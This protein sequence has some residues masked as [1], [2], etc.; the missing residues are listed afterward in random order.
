MHPVTTIN[1]PSYSIAPVLNII[2]HSPPPQ[3]SQEFCIVR[4]PTISPRKEPYDPISFLF[5]PLLLLILLI[6]PLALSISLLMLTPA[7]IQVL[8]YS[9][10]HCRR[11]TLRRTLRLFH[12]LRI[13]LEYR[14]ERRIDIPLFL[15]K[16]RNISR[17]YAPCMKTL[18][19]IPSFDYGSHVDHSSFERQVRDRGGSGVCGREVVVGVM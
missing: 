18:R 11:R 6:V 7:T 15:R 5:L 9:R 19:T 3:P 8:P 14:H 1:S 17:V 4:P 16:G 12:Q 2:L 13:R 10:P